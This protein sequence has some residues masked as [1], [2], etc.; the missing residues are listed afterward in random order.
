[1]NP[2]FPV[3][4]FL[5]SDAAR[6]GMLATLA[7]LADAGATV[8]VIERAA[9]TTRIVSPRRRSRRRFWSPSS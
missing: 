5:P 6:E 8:I 9:R 1:V 2:G 3:I 7:R 4:A